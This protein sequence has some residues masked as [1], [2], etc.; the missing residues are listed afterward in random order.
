MKMILTGGNQN[1]RVDL[2]ITNTKSPPPDDKYVSL[3][4]E[5][6][7]D[8]RDIGAKGSTIE[9]RFDIADLKRSI[10]SL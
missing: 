6:V 8:N 9:A 5:I 2:T 3:R 7:S 10:R 1:G 4:L